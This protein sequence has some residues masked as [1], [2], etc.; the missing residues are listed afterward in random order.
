M[1]IIT[2]Q[3][4]LNHALKL[5]GRA[6]GNGKSHPILA[7][8]LIDAMENGRLQISAFDLELGITT[9]ILASVDRWSPQH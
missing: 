3:S 8:V 2:T 6:V 9:S 1:K 5:V 7:D 4:D